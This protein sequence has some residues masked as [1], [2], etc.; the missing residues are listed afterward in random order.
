MPDGRGRPRWDWFKDVFGVIPLP[1]PAD[2][3]TVTFSWLTDMFGVVPEH[4]SE[5]QVRRH[6]Q[7]WARFLLTLDE[8]DPR[9]LLYRTQLDRMTHRDFVCRPYMTPEVAFVADP[10]IWRAEHMSLWTSM[11]TLIYFGCIEWHQVDRV[12]PQFGGVQNSPH[13]QVN[14]DW[15]HARD[16]RGVEEVQDPGPSADY[17]RWWFLAG[18]QYLAPADAFFLRPPN[19]IP[20]EAFDKVADMP[21]T[22]RVDDAP[23]NRRPDRR[24]MVGGDHRGGRRGGRA[25]GRSN[26]A[27]GGASSSQAHEVG[28]TQQSE[29]PPT[30][31]AHFDCGTPTFGSLSQDFLVRLNSPGFQRTLQQIFTRDTIYRPYVDGSHGQ[32]Q[33]DLNEPASYP[34]HMFMTYAGTPPSAYTPEP[35]VVA[36]ETAPDPAPDD[37]AAHDRD[38]DEGGVPMGRGRRVPRRRGCGTWGH[39]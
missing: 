25:G 12:I 1:G 17:F 33:V 20:P 30:P 3:C 39:M 15:L 26:P 37:P 8:R 34:S 35:Y 36:S 31:Q 4:A 2:T 27:H 23:D 24:R 18:K 10:S 5:I 21:H 11:Y 6:A 22:Y 16:G 32:I 29:V 28:T 14:I 7:A 13:R 9:V 19:E 38:G